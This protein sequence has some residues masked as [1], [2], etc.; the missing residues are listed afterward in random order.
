MAVESFLPGTSEP[1]TTIEKEVRQKPS[2]DERTTIE[3]PG[4]QMPADEIEQDKMQVKKPKKRSAKP[5]RTAEEIEFVR[6]STLIITEKPQ[7]ALKI[8]SALGNARKY[9]DN[10]V[11][12]YELTR[13]SKKIIVA[14]AV[15]HLFN[16]TYAEGERGWPIFKTEW[17]PS[18]ERAAF[19][20]RYYEL[21]K[22]LAKRAKEIIIAT[23]YDIEG[24][25]IG[26][27]IL[28]FIV[29]QEDA[30]RMKFSTLT[31]PELEKAYDN[32]MP[33]LDWGQAYAG[34]TR[35][36]LDWLYGINLS[37]ALMSA[38]K[39]A[40]SFRVL[41]I[42]RIQ[43]PTLKL[44]VDRER[45]ITA[46]K[47]EPYW[48]VF[49]HT[50]N[51]PYKYVKDI[52]NKDE[53][54]EFEHI[55]EANAAT[56][57]KTEHVEPPHPFD[58]TTLQREAYGWHRISP[59]R[60]LQV[61]QS[62]YL[63]GLISYPRTS[64]QKL[65]PEIEP[66]KIL[67]TLEKQFPIAEKATR[68]TPIEGPKSD[69]AHPA[70][71]PTGEVASLDNDEKKIYELI[72]KRFI[73]AFS[74]DAVLARTYSTLTAED[75]KFTA[76]GTA[77]IEKGWMDIYPSTVEEST[78]PDLNGP[79]KIDKI[80]IAEK[81]TQPPK[82]YTP[83]SLITLLEKKNL[84]TKS[85]RSVIIETL[86]ERGYLE[87]KSIQATPLGMKLIL[88]L[89]KYS[90]II[91][92]ENLT[93]DLEEKMEDIQF[94]NDN[95]K[96]KEKAVLADVERIIGNIAREFKE[97]EIEIGQALVEGSQEL[98]EQ[99]REQSI[100]MPCP[101]CKIGM[102]TIKYSKKT[103]RQFAACTKYPECKATYSL[104]PNSLIKKT[105]K[106]SENNLP[107]LMALRKGRKP[108]IFEFNPNYKKEV[109]KDKNSN[110][111]STSS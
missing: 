20:R 101:Q 10:N 57:K 6:D 26:W 51:T 12:F 102:L 106:M 54:K 17:V 24:E 79:V 4:R 47:P 97:K 93:R 25:V 38:I 96:E 94:K 80:E 42:G 1:K 41:S 75:K 43:G 9:N 14:S 37:R 5:K 68:Q 15:G 82:R 62:L 3:T 65:P 104:P 90:P 89:E 33:T 28:R 109:Q 83:A 36:H 71:Y 21:I 2:V 86:F 48:Q 87:G 18:Y 35:H 16:L 23:D 40:G 100:I 84:G 19:T 49:A 78:V 108:W 91:I 27:N 111:P 105:D 8:A 7:A 39:K 64:S 13:N 103:K 30:K 66:K 58:L 92:D 67:K 63:D 98:R 34:E 29:K 77:V 85:T 73:A 22:K 55:K 107:L 61:A 56:T 69:P 46:F 45:E 81:E 60:T 88:S 110:Q 76:N 11:S 44:I 50:H 99:Q 70:I 52:F 95:R 31:K 72:V 32:P 59:A 74:S 53:L